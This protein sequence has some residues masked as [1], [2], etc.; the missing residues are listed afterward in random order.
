M[1]Y[2]NVRIQRD[3]NT[4]YQR[5]VPPWEIPILEFVFGEGNVVPLG[6]YTQAPY[7]YPEPAAEHQRLSLRYGVDRETKTDFVATVYGAS[8]IGI[9]E[10]GKAIEVARQAELAANRNRRRNVKPAP[11]I[12][13]PLLN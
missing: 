12:V 5:A 13:D 6:T 9:R 7:P 8:R 10:I 4:I 1:R 3:T 2:E 11:E